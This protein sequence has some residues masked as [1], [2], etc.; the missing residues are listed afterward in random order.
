VQTIDD[1]L[2]QVIEFDKTYPVA[3]LKQIADFC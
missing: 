2:T 1:F 3:Q